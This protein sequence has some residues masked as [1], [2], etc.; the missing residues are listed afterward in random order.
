MSRANGAMIQFSADV[1]EHTHITEIK[2][3]AQVGNNQ[4]LPSVQIYVRYEENIV[5]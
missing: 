2:D 4:P 5:T 1:T 3:P